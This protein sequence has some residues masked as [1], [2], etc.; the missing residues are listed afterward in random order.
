MGLLGWTRPRSWCWLLL[1]IQAGCASLPDS[2]PDAHVVSA[3]G[4]AAAALAA[5]GTGIAPV[6]W[7]EAVRPDA[8]DDEP[9]KLP[10]PRGQADRKGE[11]PEQLPMPRVQNPLSASSELTPDAVVEQVLARNPS[12]AQMVAAWKAADARYPQ[13]TSLDDP[14][15]G[16]TVGPA[17]I[18]SR[19]VDF[20]YRVEIS[21]KYPWHG[22]LELRGKNAQAFASAA[23]HDVLDVKLQ[24]AEAARTAFFDYYLASRALEVNRESLRLLREFR[25]NALERYKNRLAPEQDLRQADVEI[26]R[27]QERQLTLE[28]MRRVAVAR[29]NTLMNLQP[30]SPLPGPPER[31]KIEGELPDAAVLR[32]LALTRRPDLR[33]LADRIDAEKASLG[34]AEKEFYPDFE[35]VAAYDAFW[36]RPEQDLRPQLA[37]RMNLPVRTDRRFA[38]VAEAQARIAQREAELA[39]QVA[40]VS[41]DVQQAYEQV[42]ESAKAARLYEDTIL[43]AAQENVKAA[44]AAYTT[45]RVPFLSLIEAQRNLV[46]LRDR[47]Y[48]VTADYFRRRAQLERAV[49]GPFVAVP[50][51]FL[52]APKAEKR[53]R[54]DDPGPAKGKR[55]R[56]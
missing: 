52:P 45:N 44:L 36:Q 50:L 46:G 48:E 7:R 3:R 34:L 54:A 27:Q 30:D 43:P 13:V 42:Q 12:V 20:A 9:E 38:A 53:D 33:A 31:L 29:I 24:L 8:P 16:A 47:S 18:F 4:Q 49:G 14:T 56:D 17:S 1:C 55:D 22:K 39:R 2:G 15:F 41:Y 51:V 28:R 23:G 10:A 35:V 26:G 32:S 40:Q 11:K 5:P 37:V 21:Q 25:E 19:D 6:A